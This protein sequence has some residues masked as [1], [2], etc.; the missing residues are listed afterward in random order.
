MSDEKPAKPDLDTIRYAP[1]DGLTYNPN[2]PKYWDKAALDKE[3]TRAFDLCQGCR[4]C[5]KFCQSFP[6]LFAA[7]DEHGDVRRLPDAA[8]R[9]V[10]DECFQCKLCYTQCPYTDAEGHPFRLDF[11]R[12][13]MRANAVRRREEGIPLR[14]R[15]LGNPDGLARL[16]RPTAA[17]ANFANTLRPHRILMEKVMG[18]HRDKLLPSFAPTSFAQW[19]RREVSRAPAGEA[20][21]DPVVLFA[22]C[23]VNHNR[24]EV[25]KAAYRVLRHNG[26]RVA[27]P[28]LNCCGMPALDGGDVAFAIKQ[29]KSNV[30]AL[31][32]FVDHGYRVAVLNP[33]C[34]LMLRQEY[35]ELLDD[36]ADRALA[37]AAKKVAAAT[38]DAS[39]FLFELRKEGRFKEDFRSTPNGNV[40]YH[41]PCHLRMQNV[42]FRGRDLMRRIPQVRPVLTAECCGHDGTWAMKTE[43]FPIALKYG[44][45]A[46]DGMREADAELWTTDCPLAAL[47]FEQ[48]CGKKALHPIEVLDRAYREDGFPTPVPAAAEAAAAPAKGA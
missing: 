8:R 24:P 5:F 43:Y 17:L 11:P 32:P 39:E 4:M 42:G 47:Q 20:Q 35:P 48:A 15:L 44:S 40:A 34:S 10:I 29:A 36:P 33:T 16:A 21:G 19:A 45:K 2:E 14:E 23:F 18:I 3:I 9:R 13:L 38:R 26:C 22:T 31:L 41:A 30:R 1:T 25:G 46:F 6:T 7:V 27:C 37:E 12:L 28:P